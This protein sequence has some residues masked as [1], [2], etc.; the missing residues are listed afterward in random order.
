MN[1]KTLSEKILDQYIE[2]AKEV[3]QLNKTLSDNIL[4]LAEI[5]IEIKIDYEKVQNYLRS[6]N[7]NFSE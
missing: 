1:D 6:N 3:E 5:G 7:M 2:N 4:K